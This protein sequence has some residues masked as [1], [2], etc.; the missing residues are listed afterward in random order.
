MPVNNSNSGQQFFQV[1]Q[2]HIRQQQ[3]AR[4]LKDLCREVRTGWVNRGLT[5]P[6]HAHVLEKIE[7]LVRPSGKR[8]NRGRNGALLYP[9]LTGD[10]KIVLQAFNIILGIGLPAFP[11]MNEVQALISY[12]RS[13]G[14]APKTIQELFELRVQLVLDDMRIKARR[15]LEARPVEEEDDPFAE[16]PDPFS[17]LEMRPALAVAAPPPPPPLPPPPPPPVSPV[18]GPGQE[19]EQ[20]RSR[21]GS[22]SH[23]IG[24]IV[25]DDDGAPLGPEPESEPEPGPQPLRGIHR[26]GRTIGDPKVW[27]VKEEGET[28]VIASSSKYIAGTS[29]RHNRATKKHGLHLDPYRDG[30][31]STSHGGDVLSRLEGLAISQK[32]YEED[33]VED[34]WDD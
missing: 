21:S 28:M 4:P 8:A 18:G 10:L 32:V 16:A 24:G 6:W 31:T 2:E 25:D 14:D 17:V 7:R 34:E 30:L 27:D 19:Q 22:G 11:H 29:A 15:Q 5:L 1:L 23:D 20:V 13:V 3:G 33:E 9:V 12:A 26:P